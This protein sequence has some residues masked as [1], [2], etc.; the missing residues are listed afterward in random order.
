M[1]DQNHNTLNLRSQPLFQEQ[2]GTLSG[3]RH[4]QERRR[5]GAK[6]A[7]VRRR[8]RGVNPSSTGETV[9]STTP[10]LGG[11]GQHARA[12]PRN[13]HEWAG[14]GEHGRARPHRGA[15]GGWARGSSNPDP[16]TCRH[17]QGRYRACG[18][19]SRVQLP[20]YP[21]RQAGDEKPLGRPALRQLRF[22][23]MTVQQFMQK[24][25]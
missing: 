18:A 5:G 15:R 22:H 6:A 16:R 8:M 24:A 13:G 12:G 17:A 2:A 4:C 7:T 9:N 23:L 21:D 1:Y 25:L 10:S 20:A 3:D 14:G 11:W 19:Q